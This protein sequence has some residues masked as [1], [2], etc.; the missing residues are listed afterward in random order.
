MTSKTSCRIVF[1]NIMHGGGSR[2]G[3]IVEQIMD[4]KPDIVALA[5]FRGT[6]HS[7]S[8]ANRLFEAGLAY[9]LTAVNADE[10]TWNAVFLASRFKLNHVAQQLPEVPYG[11]LYW[12]LAKVEAAPSFHVGVVH[13][14]WAIRDGR[15]EYYA[16]LVKVAE[17]WQFGPGLI[18]GDTNCAL[19]GLDEDTENSADF[20]ERF[21]TPLARHGWRDMFRAFHPQEN[22][23]T[24]YSSSGNGFRLDHAYVNALVRPYIKSCV[25]DWGRAWEG[26][27]LS[28]HAAILLDLDLGAASTTTE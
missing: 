12:L 23:P 14:P 11:D 4:W 6:K 19:T 18:I 25:H 20:K 16:A 9:Q 8:I 2:A 24:W 22:A 10:P 15:L 3:G 17:N 13:A 1:W 26:K 28:D 5:E 21:V 7:Q 27:K